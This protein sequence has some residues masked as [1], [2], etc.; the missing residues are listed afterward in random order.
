[1]KKKRDKKKA[2]REKRIAEEIKKR[3]FEES[4]RQEELS[5][6]AQD[7]KIEL[8]ALSE[9]SE[10]APEEVAKIAQ[11]VRAELEGRADLR[12]AGKR[13]F[14][15]VIGLFLAL[16]ITA[17]III[18]VRDDMAAKE[19]LKAES[20]VKLKMLTLHE[21]LKEAVRGGNAELA[22]YLLDNGAPIEIYM[23]NSAEGAPGAYDSVLFDAASG[24]RIQIVKSLLRRGADVTRKNQRGETVLDIAGSQG[25]HSLVL[26][27]GKAMADAYPKEHPVRRLW[28]KSIPFSSTAFVEQVHKSNSEAVRLFIQGGM[29]IDAKGKIGQYERTAL[30]VAAWD[31][32]IE[33]IRLLLQITPPGKKPELNDPLRSAI[34]TNKI[35]AVKILLEA[36]AD[37][38]SAAIR[39][40]FHNL[41]I[42]KLLLDFGADVNKCTGSNEWPALA[43]ALFGSIGWQAEDRKKIVRFLLD[44]GALTENRCKARWNA[45]ELARSWGDPEVIAWIT[46]ASN[47]D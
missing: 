12:K 20:D 7:R 11:E 42:A 23:E 17:F 34:W 25:Y 15:Y 2:D 44:N 21:E 47:K 43:D 33:M 24:E 5:R 27:F 8:D 18:L 1:M 28:A 40:A 19:K 36:G 9:V 32:N 45:L 14:V 35:H 3:V 22:E 16:G 29:D 46:A 10:L 26:I 38:D 30:D 37:P 4:S 13:P 39:D 31:G 6:Q 41:R